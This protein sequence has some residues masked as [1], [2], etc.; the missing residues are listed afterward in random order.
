MNK[1]VFVFLFVLPTFVS[2]QPQIFS[3]LEQF[4]EAVGD[5]H[6]EDFE[7]ARVEPGEEVEIGSGVSAFSDDEV[8]SPGEIVFGLSFRHFGTLTA[9]GEGFNGQSSKALSSLFDY[10]TSI[11][12]T[13]P[14]STNAFAAEFRSLTGEEF[15]LCIDVV[16]ADESM[17][18]YKLQLDSTEEFFGLAFD[19]SIIRMSLFVAQPT[20]KFS[21]D[22]FRLEDNGNLVL[23]EY[24]LLEKFLESF[25]IPTIEDFEE[26][27]I[28]GNTTADIGEELTSQTS[29]SVVFPG[30]IS[31]GVN[32]L[33]W[34]GFNLHLIG[35]G[36]F[37]SPG[38][39]I[40]DPL[41][42]GIAL[43]F[44]SERVDAMGFSIVP[45]NDDPNKQ[46]NILLLNGTTLVA[47]RIHVL[48]SEPSFI[49]FATQLPVDRVLFRNLPEDFEQNFAIDTVYFLENFR[50]PV[51]SN[52]VP[53]GG[54]GN[55]LSGSFRTVPTSIS[56]DGGTVIGRSRSGSD[57]VGFCWSKEQGIEPID[58]PF[59]FDFIR[60]NDVSSDG[61]K[62]AGQVTTPEG[63]LFAIRL[64]ANSQEYDD[65]GSL[66]GTSIV[67]TE[68]SAD[69]SAIIGRA[70]GRAFRWNQENGTQ[71]IGPKGAMFASANS[72]TC[73]GAIVVGTSMGD[74]FIWTESEEVE[75]LNDFLPQAISG[76]GRFIVGRNSVTDR[77][78]RR[79]LVGGSVVDMGPSQSAVFFKAEMSDDGEVFLADVKIFELVE[80]V[81][82]GEIA[83]G[84]NFWTQELGFVSLPG[85][86]ELQNTNVLDWNELT[87]LVALSG[88][89]RTF[90]G[91]GETTYGA[92]E[93]FV[94][95]IVGPPVFGD[96]N[97]DGELN[98]LDIG[99]FIETL[100]DQCYRP[101]GDMNHDGRL[102]LL[103][104]APFVEALVD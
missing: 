37:G 74:G 13:L 52:I 71:E 100:A 1:L 14:G 4:V 40:S 16:L 35:E 32:L 48:G 84:S 23:H 78:E 82:M 92:T 28:P 65:L 60:P 33:S 50:L 5:F 61:A 38:K 76:D 72:M 11:G 104:I 57:E 15:E 101:I 7:E 54:L 2:A 24:D 77:L 93:A 56:K 79:D 25:P 39:A 10:A 70:I 47:E 91:I 31:G 97:G 9:V 44:Q 88:D 94:V 53:L 67:P 17:H 85:L 83:N 55:D 12:V 102:N 66:N 46:L 49:G 34:R 18:E 3:N 6:I 51:G 62:I 43:D 29:N 20:H 80:S 75:I 89:G 81:D 96:V 69:G 98:L 90:T 30:H 68:I 26:T 19:M 99:P 73:D 103:D 41:A 8:F 22:N 64:D 27:L 95:D 36:Y 59:E 45:L 63:G 42:D 86:F 87:D 58:L 21:I